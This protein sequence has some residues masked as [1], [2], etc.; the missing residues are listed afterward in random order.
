MNF[1]KYLFLVLAL[2]LLLTGCQTNMLGFS[3]ESKNWNAELSILQTAGKEQATILLKYQGA[4]DI[5]AIKKF[6]YYVKRP[7]FGF[8]G[9]AQLNKAG[10][11]EGE[12]GG[13]NEG[14]TK[15]NVE[16]EVTVTWNNNTET[17]ILK[18]MK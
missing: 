12:S 7:R 13:L 17:I 14:K 15:S 9:T 6:N 2:L 18:P 1:I 10:V 4:N 11:Y 16:I 5:G 3:G 8:G